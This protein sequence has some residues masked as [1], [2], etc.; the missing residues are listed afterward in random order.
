MRSLLRRLPWRLRD[1]A[2]FGLIELLIA[3]TVL[4]VGV[5]ATV[6]V[7]ETSLLHLGRAT[8]VATATAVGE[9]EMED[10]RAVR[11]DAIALDATAF[12][13]ALADATYTGDSACGGTCT[14]PGTGAG[15]SVVA[16]G[17]GFLPTQTLAGADGKQYRVDTYATWQTVPGGR[18][19]KQIVVVVRDSAGKVWA[20]ISS[21]FDESTGL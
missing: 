14:T 8:K 5:L 10:F 2:G 21:S 20:R 6:A 12:A 11:F 1:E 17:S 3:L 7:F 9:Q 18:P 4:V 16:V 15:Q 19:V 13:T